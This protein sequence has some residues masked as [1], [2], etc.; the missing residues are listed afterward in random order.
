MIVTMGTGMLMS[1][2]FPPIPPS[3]TPDQVAAFYTDNPNQTRFG[4]YLVAMGAALFVPW[5]AILADQIK[6]IPG[7]T[8][9]LVYTQFGAGVGNAVLIILPAL[10]FSAAAY[11]PEIDPTFTYLLHDL[12]WIVFIMSVSLGVVQFAA[13]GL[14]ILVDKRTEPA[15]PR[16]AGYLNFWVAV[17]LFPAGLILFFKTG[18][19]TWAGA[20]SYYLPFGVFFAMFVAMFILLRR[21]LERQAEKE[22]GGLEHG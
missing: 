10:L 14:A 4:F 20:F 5:S 15:F 18:P 12:C 16:W 7:V 8:T 9:A 1:G 13:L 17:G 21:L 6:R 2:L 11:R 3:A 22:A 19:F